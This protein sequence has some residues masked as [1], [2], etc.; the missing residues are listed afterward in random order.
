MKLMDQIN[1]TEFVQMLQKKLAPPLVTLLSA[2]AEIQVMFKSAHLIT[3]T[4]SKLITISHSLVF[5]YVVQCID[6]LTVID[7]KSSLLFPTCTLYIVQC[8]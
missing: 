6:A 8:T 3:A 4:G 2:E 5:Y 1:N 7:I